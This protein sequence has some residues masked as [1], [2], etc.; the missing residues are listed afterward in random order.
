MPEASVPESSVKSLINALD[1]FLQP[2]YRLFGYVPS[3]GHARMYIAGR[4]QQLDRRTLEPIATANGVHRRPLQQFVGAGQWSD[5]PVREQMCR[6]V[7][8]EL[9]TPDGVLI[10]DGSGFQKWGTESVGVQRQWCGRL[11]KKENC[12]VGEFLAYAS[13]KGHTLVDC[14][15]YLPQSWAEDPERREKTYVPKDAQFRK[16]WELALDM[17]E[18]RATVLPHRWVLGDDA[19]GRVVEARKRLDSMGERYLLEIPSNTLV[20]LRP[21]DKKAQ[22]VDAVAKSIPSKQWSCVRTRDGEKGPIEVRAVKMRVTTGNS[23]KK[24]E[25]RRETLLIV[26]NPKTGQHWYYLSNAKGFSVKKMTKAAAC[27]HYIEESLEHGKGE[28][29]LAEYEVRSWVGWH[30]HMTLSML[31]LLFLA[32]EKQRLCSRCVSERP[33]PSPRSRQ[34]SR[35]S[36][37]AMRRLAAITG[38]AGAVVHPRER[39]PGRRGAD[40]MTILHSPTPMRPVLVNLLIEMSS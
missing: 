10:M 2:F 13:H 6:T 11:G 8:D 31:A 28:V 26:R 7:A 4:M 30:H 16:G 20:R 32:I 37:V 23:K 15:L 14:R 24:E 36:C 25:R 33:T 29:G 21:G 27:R 19:Y 38:E 18:E 9:G 22:R 12:Q 1:G 17:V 5:V 35:N 34:T 40:R 3:Q 39:P